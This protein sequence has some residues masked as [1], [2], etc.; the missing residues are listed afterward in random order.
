MAQAARQLP[1]SVRLWSKAADLETELKAKKR[2]FR[3]G[4]H[5][6]APCQFDPFDQL[7]LH[8]ELDF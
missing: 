1:N 2:V 4:K 6:L 8:D 7:D 3:K 5:M